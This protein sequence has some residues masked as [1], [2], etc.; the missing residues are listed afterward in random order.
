M[1]RGDDRHGFAAWRG[2]GGPPPKVQRRAIRIQRVR[3]EKDLHAVEETI[4]I[5]V[6]IERIRMVN[7]NFLEIGQAVAIRIGVVWIGADQ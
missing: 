1:V 3:S 7:E 6:R 5:R 4:P 2:Y